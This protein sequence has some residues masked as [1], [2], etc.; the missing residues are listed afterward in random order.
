M[1]YLADNIHEGHRDRLKNEFINGGFNDN[2]PDYKWLELLLFYSIPQKDTN[3]LAHELINRFKSLTGVL[4]APIEELT[5]FKGI[6]KNTA[7]LLK[8][9]IPIARKCELEKSETLLL[10]LNPENLYE[11]V[12]KQFYGLTTERVGVLLLDIVGRI[13]DFRFLGEGDISEVGISVRKIVKYALDYDATNL[14]LAHNHPKGFA[15][16][17]HADINATVQLNDMLRKM[18]IRLIDHIII[19]E[20]DYVSLSQSKEYSFIFK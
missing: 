18:N 7:T 4:E 5:K 16:P 2:T 15:L 13:I 11:Y 19:S 1:K 12:F 3:P 17:S 9:I 6:T 10:A 14:I 8:L 20:D